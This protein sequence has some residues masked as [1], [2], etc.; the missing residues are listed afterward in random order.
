M[1]SE[2][3]FRKKIEWFVQY[4]GIATVAVIVAIIVCISLVKA[5]IMPAEY[6]D[7]CILIYSDEISAEDAD[8]ICADLQDLTGKTIS[9]LRYGVSDTYGSQSFALKLSDTVLDIVIA[10]EEETQKLAQNGFLFEYKEIKGKDL[11]LG[12]SNRARRGEL[13][14][15]VV[16]ALIVYLGEN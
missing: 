12:V 15:E 16:D 9:V 1:F 14:D 7:V 11:Y 13:L 8:L 10:P 3:P 2:L 6:E 5:I 4:Y